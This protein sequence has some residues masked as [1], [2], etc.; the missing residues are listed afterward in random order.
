MARRRSQVSGAWREWER[1]QRAAERSRAETA[2]QQEQQRKSQERAQILA[3]QQAGTAQA[4]RTTEQL[5]RRVAEL[6][7]LLHSS[8]G[9]RPRFDLD[10]RSVGR[11]P[12]LDLGALASPLPGPS[13]AMFA[14]AEPGPVG[15]LFGGQGRY[16]RELARARDAFEQARKDHARA[17]LERQRKVGEARRGDARRRAAAEGAV[18]QDNARA[19]QFARAVRAGERHAVAEYF[20]RVLAQSAY[21]EGP[22]MPSPEMKT[23][24]KAPALLRRTQNIRSPGR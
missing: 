9:W 2:R 6:D 7:R 4:A 19:E 12:R 23:G 3:R 13:W 10:A 24:E 15:R 17:E 8:L 5:G 14:P 21:P 1:Q 20:R 11:H 18:A 22:P 16:E